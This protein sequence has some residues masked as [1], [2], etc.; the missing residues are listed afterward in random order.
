[1][2]FYF[3]LA[4]FFLLGNIQFTSGQDGVPLIENVEDTRKD[5]SAQE[6]E[7]SRE[8]FT[9]PEQDSNFARAMRSPLPLSTIYR[10]FVNM[11]DNLLKNMDPD[12]NPDPWAIAYM[13]LNSINPALYQPT[14]M[15]VVQRQIAIENAFY[16]P[17]T[18]T[19][20]QGGLKIPF[21]AIGALLGLNEDVS[22]KI[23]YELEFTANV[24]VSIYSANALL[25]A[26]LFEG[27]QSP[28]S[29]TFT[30]NLRNSE[31]K[32]MPSG[33]YIAEVRIANERYIYKKV[34]IP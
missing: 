13:N 33:D 29:Y 10:N 32:K 8:K 6:N 27:V 14:E 5:T 3:F 11:A 4:I 17:Y 2:K 12:A 24:K 28:G 15:E 9:T 21:S 34:V 30:W 19:Y 25:I 20:Q 7:L 26:T 1:M 22:P 16:V 18:N 31:G 23:T